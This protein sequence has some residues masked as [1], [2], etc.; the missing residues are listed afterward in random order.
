METGTFAVE[1]RVEEAHWWFVGRR[2]LFAREIGRL[3]LPPDAGVL[4]IGTGTGSGLRM[5]RDCGFRNVRGVDASDD[6]IAFAAAKG[7]GRVERGSIYAV[8]AA[9][10]SQALVLATDV[11]EH[12]D[13]DIRALREVARVLA[14]GGYLLLT[15][16]AFP[17]LWGLQDQRAHHK[18]RYRLQP[19]RRLLESAGIAPLRSYYFNYLLFGPIWLARQAIRVLN[20]DLE[21]ENEVN[22]PVINGL[23]T[24]IFRLDCATAPWVRP[25]FGVSALVLGRKAPR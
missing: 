10:A 17:S 20:V 23:L 7:L 22:S 12:V 24:P 5:L 25:P 21:S 14:P 2:R 9:D 19:L 8:P 1:A 15:V 6:A 13:D 16:P 11:I 4:D 18:R 3:G